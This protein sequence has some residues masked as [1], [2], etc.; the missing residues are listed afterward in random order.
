MPG[1]ILLVDDDRQLTSFLERYLAKQGFA[2]TVAAS[3]TQMR[4]LI[5]SRDFDMI[6]LDL[7]L[8]DRDGM[9]VM[10]DVRK[11]S[12]IPI[13]LMTVRDEVIDRVF[14][15]ELGADD[16][17]GKPFEPR[18]LLARIRTVLRR[19]QV[20]GAQNDSEPPE[21]LR[22]AGYTLDLVARS[23]KRDADGAEI[24][25]TSTEFELLRVLASS[26]GNALSRERMLSMIYGRTVQVTDRA[27]DAHIA[28]LRRK[29]DESDARAT[30]IQT[31]HGVGYTFAAT[32]MSS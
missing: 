3:A 11:V 21:R 30:L 13:I 26:N 20:P 18:E 29:L 8:P 6:L 15:L 25:L 14:G 24:S 7:G 2:A 1:H 19:T 17:L 10:R 22:F 32:V 16:Y 4:L 31:V 9:E 23:L 28:R 5:G 12:D 27:I